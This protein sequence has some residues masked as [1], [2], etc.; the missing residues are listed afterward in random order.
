MEV[1]NKITNVVKAP[2]PALRIKTK[3]VKKITPGLLTIAKEMIKLTKTFKDPEGVGLASTQVGLDGRFFV[4]IANNPKRA[5]KPSYSAFFNPQILSFS[6]NNKNHFEGC[7]ST[8][9]IWGEVERAISV[10]VSYQDESGQTIIKT[11]TGLLAHI[12]QHEIDHLNGILFQD[13]V[14]QQGGKFYKWMGRDASTGEDKFQEIT[15]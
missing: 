13:R 3:P 15:I 4:G 5:E 11:V 14:M 2:N 1:M 7:L 10:R 12:F 6:K 9:N 8:P